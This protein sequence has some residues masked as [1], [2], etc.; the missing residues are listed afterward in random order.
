MTLIEL[1][2]KC[3]YEGMDYIITQIEP[4]EVEDVE[5]AQ[6]LKNVQN[7][8]NKIRKILNEHFVPYD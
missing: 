4:E 6:L 1:A 3:D 7:D 8:Y 2:Q 5:L